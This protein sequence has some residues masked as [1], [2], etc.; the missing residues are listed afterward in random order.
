MAEPPDAFAVDIVD[1]ILLELSAPSSLGRE[2]T[3]DFRLG[4]K[5]EIAEFRQV[6]HRGPRL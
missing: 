4:I 2:E 6:Y 1:G 3:T 5:R